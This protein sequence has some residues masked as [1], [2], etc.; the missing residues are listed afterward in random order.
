MVE[1]R[2]VSCLGEVCS[3]SF[4]ASMRAGGLRRS[5]ANEAASLMAAA[6]PAVYGAALWQGLR[7]PRC[8]L[9]LGR[10]C[11]KSRPCPVLPG[12]MGSQAAMLSL[13]VLVCD[14][15]EQIP[16]TQKKMGEIGPGYKRYSFE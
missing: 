9:C 12:C 3:D 4:G 7:E 16:L 13:C 8:M 5:C 2:K 11:G 1:L 15:S 6:C 10:P 14:L